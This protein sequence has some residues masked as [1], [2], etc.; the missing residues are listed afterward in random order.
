MEE[1]LGTTVDTRVVLQPRILEADM[2][3]ISRFENVAQKPISL[4]DSNQ[5]TSH[6]VAHQKTLDYSPLTG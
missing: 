5:L 1:L 3:L 4:N 2:C 6:V